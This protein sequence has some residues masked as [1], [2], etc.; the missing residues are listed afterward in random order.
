MIL[1][2]LLSGLYFMLVI[3]FG[4]YFLLLYSKNFNQD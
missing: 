1:K 4:A 2:T 3:H